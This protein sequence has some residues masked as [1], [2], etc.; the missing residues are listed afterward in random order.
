MLND[1]PVRG[2]PFGGILFVGERGPVSKVS[3]AAKLFDRTLAG[4]L[5]HRIV[6]IVVGV[7]LPLALVASLVHALDSFVRQSG[8]PGGS[9]LNHQV[10]DQDYIIM[11]V[12]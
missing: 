9:R 3:V 11:V 8:A 6:V 1:V 5:P 4:H 7:E 10:A 12:M 2:R